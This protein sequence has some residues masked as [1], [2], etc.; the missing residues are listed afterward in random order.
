M[1][2]AIVLGKGRSGNAAAELLRREGAD[3]VILDGADVF[4][5]VA[6]AG[7]A[8]CVTSPGV[9]LTH[10]W[11]VRARELGIPVISE[12]QL[13]ASRFRGRMLAVTG[14]KG[15]SSVV[16]MVADTLSAQPG[17]VGGVACGNYGKPLCEVVNEGFAGWA[18][19]EVSSFQMET[20]REFHPVAAAV[21]NLQ[22]DHLD[23]H[24]S[25]EVYHGLKLR[26]A[27]M[28]DRRIMPDASFDTLLAG[29]YFDNAILRENGEIAAGLLRAAGLDDEAIAAGFA[30]FV[31]LHHRM[32]TVLE[33]R[34]VVYVDDSKA[35]SLAATAAGVT[36]ASERFSA[37][38][39]V[40]L[41]A[42]GLPKGDD[43]DSV[44][45]VLSTHCKKVYLIGQ[46]AKAFYNSWK[47][48]V[49]C[50]NCGT[51]DEAVKASGRD[52]EGG[53][54][55][56]LSPGTASFDQFKSYGERGDAFAS[57]ARAAEATRA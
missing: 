20:T 34:G 17:G 39:R 52:A 50:E 9:P 19:V 1:M 4:P 46:S 21:L 16:K 27:S 32:E 28:A 38:G 51:M 36:M 53:D 7:D 14:S 26:M 31:P 2:K 5:P 44:K 10:D 49:P 15:K 45:E 25:V 56:L 6:D 54:V 22:E 23:R 13:G 42:G 18:V 55:V 48:I 43:P 47:D 57:A 12:L 40:L 11:Q 33:A 41:V 24:G 37:K 3:V 35:T 8:L 29:S 30:A